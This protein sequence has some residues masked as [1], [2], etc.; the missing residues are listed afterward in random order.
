LFQALKKIWWLLALCG[1]IEAMVA[2]MHLLMLN[3]DGSLS[4]RR[5]AVPNT[6][7]DMSVLALVS[8]ACAMIAGVWSAGKAGSWLL[9]LHGLALGVFGL[10]G[11]S[12]L[13]KGPLSFRPISLLFAAMAVSAGA[14]AFKTAD[15]FLTISG[16]ASLAFAL[17]FLAVGFGGV[18]LGPQFF[19]I[20]MS[21]YF[22]LSAILMLYVSVRARTGGMNREDEAIRARINADE[23]GF[24]GFIG[25]WFRGK[26]P[27]AVARGSHGPI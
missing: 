2:V 25:F 16:A 19:W 17:S 15:R 21:S 23:R 4:L 27:V 26:D 24:R 20:W 12:P 14:F 1:V 13:V 9:A 10:I 3:L 5:F 18:K 7:W 11:V 8:G 22:G 6:V